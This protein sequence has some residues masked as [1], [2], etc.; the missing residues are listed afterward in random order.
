MLAGDAEFIAQARR[1]KVLLGAGWRQA[2]ILAAAGLVALEEGPPRLPEDHANARRL[3]EGV[4]E[5]LPGAVDLDGMRT[6]VVFVTVAGTGRSLAAWV[7]ALAAQGVL[8]TTVAG[9]V[10][11]LT[12]RDVA[13]GD[14]D[15]ALAAWR[16][17]ADELAARWPARRDHHSWPAEADTESTA[18]PRTTWPW[19]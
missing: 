18:A 14:V 10:R 15:T 7:T 4:A 3:A 11:M 1:L 12:H 8:V 13:P 17:A 6:N 16:T 2:G 5:L 19:R 9:K